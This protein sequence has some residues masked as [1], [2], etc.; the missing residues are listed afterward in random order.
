[1]GWMW[2]LVVMVGMAAQAVAQ[3]LP[4]GGALVPDLQ[5]IISDSTLLQRATVEVQ[6]GMG[7]QNPTWQLSQTALQVFPQKL[8]DVLAQA[9]DGVD[10]LAVTAKNPEPTYRGLTLA[11][12]RVDGQRY[13]TLLVTQGKIRVHGGDVLADDPGR[14]LEYWLFGTARIRRDLLLG[15][16]VLP[17]VTFEQCRVLGN[18]IV[19]T[20]PRQCLL[21]DQNILLETPDP[22]TRASLR[23]TDFDSCLKHGKALIYTFPR[24]CMADGGRVFTEP[25]KVYEIPPVLDAGAFGGVSATGASLTVPGVSASGVVSPAAVSGTLD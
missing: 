22:L 1:M 13:A 17:V 10:R 14:R 3:P 20:Q 23:A 24:R 6:L 11:L 9:P 12:R 15:S 21:P 7:D 5:V 19:E 25:P 16:Q 18:Q 4:Q 2:V 8:A